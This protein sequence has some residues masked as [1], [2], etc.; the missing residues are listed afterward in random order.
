MKKRAEL[1]DLN[2]NGWRVAPAGTGRSG[3]A[4]LCCS[5]LLYVS[6][7]AQ[8]WGQYSIDWSTIDGGGSTSAGG[9]Y[10]LSGTIGQPDAGAMSGGTFTLNG[11]FWPGLIVPQTGEAPALFI[12]L[13]GDLVILSWTPATD[14]FRLETTTDLVEG[15]WIVAPAG[16][17]VT[18]P[19]IGPTRFYRLKKP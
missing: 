2:S 9:Q 19:L 1:G 17:P 12:E 14:G 10:V 16:N 15:T 7:C 8:L 4:S 11:G 6:C 13:S 3:L 5:I 18:I